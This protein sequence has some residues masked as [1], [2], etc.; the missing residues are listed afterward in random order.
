MVVAGRESCQ[1]T[2]RIE[3]SRLPETRVVLLG[4]RTSSST[5]GVEAGNLSKPSYETLRA[6]RTGTSAFPALDA[7]VALAKAVAEDGCGPVFNQGAL[8][9]PTTVSLLDFSS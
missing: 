3:A 4:T 5:M 9:D 6:G 8:R 7:M 2:D 1:A